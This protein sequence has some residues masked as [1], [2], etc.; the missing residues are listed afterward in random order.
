MRIGPTFVACFA[1]TVAIAVLPGIARGVD[2]A[3]DV[4]P[5][6]V[7]RCVRCHGPD[8]QEG[9]LRL[10]SRESAL[11]AGDSGRPVIETP[12]EQNELWRRVALSEA[13]VRMPLDGPPLSETELDRLHAWAIEGARWPTVTTL[14][15]RPPQCSWSIWLDMRLRVWQPLFLR[16]RP[17]LFIGMGLLASLLV[18]SLIARRRLPHPR[19]QRLSLLATP[20]TYL[21]IVLTIAAH[22]F[23]VQ[24]TLHRER[25]TLLE[26]TLAEVRREVT[27]AH[28]QFHPPRELVRPQHPR[29]LRRTYYRGNDER[30]PQLFNG[31][32]YRTA[33][34]ELRLID[35][36][37]NQVEAGMPCS[38]GPLTLV[39]DILRARQA[40][41][42]LFSDE[43]ARRTFLSP[44][45]AD[46]PTSAGAEPAVPCDII[47]SGEHWRLQCVLG[48]VQTDG[49]QT[50][51]GRRYVLHGADMTEH[52]SSS[53]AHFGIHFDL[54]LQDGVVQPTSD[55][56]MAP[57]L[58]AAQTIATPSHMLHS[59]EWFDVR[60]IPEIDGDNS[61]DPQWLGTPEHSKAEG[62]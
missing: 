11:V 32:F 52:T 8:K 28:D 61:S 39:L 29:A 4:Q 24:A 42:V 3:R 27:A 1:V 14:A 54:H 2:F 50:I 45:N 38:E 43:L 53:V 7:S 36:T 26:T 37:G 40:A 57:L 56:W 51:A 16:L 44:R 13:E 5:I 60:P 46:E 9:G 58:Y 34:M 59:S 30:S 25:V 55:L 49:K 41:P 18:I 22:T 12:L 10:D 48:N 33:T 17:T 23:Y 47:T 31:G 62:Q 19:W 15:T 20:S 21:L 6:L 35:A